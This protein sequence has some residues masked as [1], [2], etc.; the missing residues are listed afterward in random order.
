MTNI[1]SCTAR[2]EKKSRSIQNPLCHYSVISIKW[3]FNIMCHRGHISKKNEWFR[4]GCERD[5]MWWGEMSL[6]KHRVIIVVDTRETKTKIVHAGIDLMS[7]SIFIFIFFCFLLWLKMRKVT[8]H[9]SRTNWWK[10]NEWKTNPKKTNNRKKW[11]EE[12]SVRA[13]NSKAKKLTRQERAVGETRM[14]TE[15]NQ[16][17]TKIHKRKVEKVAFKRAGVGNDGDGQS[18]MVRY[19]CRLRCELEAFQLFFVSLHAHG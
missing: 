4:N 7:F 17:K 11:M 9:A 16:C 13:P 2:H 12:K 6:P 19:Q 8:N 18:W 1:L 14:W 15:R 10:Y 5:T 3:Q